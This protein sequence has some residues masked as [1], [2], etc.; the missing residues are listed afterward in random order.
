MIEQLRATFPGG[1]PALARRLWDTIARLGGELG[2]DGKLNFLLGDGRHLFARC[3]TKLC[4]IERKAP[5]GRATLRD[6][7]MQIDF[8]EVTSAPATAVACWSSPPNRHRETK[9]AGN[10]GTPGTMWVFDQGKLRATLPSVVEALAKKI[11]LRRSARRRELLAQSRTGPASGEVRAVRAP[12]SVGARVQ[13]D[14]LRPHR[15]GRSAARR[16]RHG[17]VKIAQIASEHEHVRM[18]RRYR[19][20][21]SAV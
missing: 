2:A 15:R 6:A 7:E 19:R 21:P 10:Q 18:A 20:S 12:R 9:T 4:Y 11:A 16:R 3:G 14:C 17:Q 8:S 1:V 13:R 5:F